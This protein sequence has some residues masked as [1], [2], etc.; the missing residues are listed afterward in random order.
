[1]GEAVKVIVRC[2]PMNTREKELKCKVTKAPACVGG[3]GGVALY[4]ACFNHRSLLRMSEVLQLFFK[5]HSIPKYEHRLH[6][7][8]RLPYNT[9]LQSQCLDSV[10]QSIVTH[11][12]VPVWCKS[13]D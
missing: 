13:A 4:E 9:K 6:V 1:M 2:R 12:E 10:A 7:I 5:E 3:V 11:S 8:G